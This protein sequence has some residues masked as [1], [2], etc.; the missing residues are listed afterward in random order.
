M[1]GALPGLHPGGRRGRD[2]RRRIGTNRN[3]R[4]RCLNCC[5]HYLRG[6]IASYVQRQTATRMRAAGIAACR[7]RSERSQAPVRPRLG[8]LALC[9]GPHAVS[10]EALRFSVAAG[11]N[12]EPRRSHHM[13]VIQGYKENSNHRVWLDCKCGHDFQAHVL[14]AFKRNIGSRSPVVPEGEESATKRLGVLCLS[15]NC[16]CQISPWGPNPT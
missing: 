2:S 3:T 6:G 9:I 15:L 10:Y 1:L 8:E 4:E 12:S 5:K 7:G 16:T 14:V 13:S 11:A